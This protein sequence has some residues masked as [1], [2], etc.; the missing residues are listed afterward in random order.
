MLLIATTVSNWLLPYWIICVVQNW[1]LQSSTN[2]T[3]LKHFYLFLKTKKLYLK[4]VL[5]RIHVVLPSQRGEWQR[6]AFSN[7]QVS[8]DALASL[9]LVLE[10]PAQ[11]WVLVTALLVLLVMVVVVTGAQAAW[12]VFWWGENVAWRVYKAE[13]ELLL[14]TEI[15]IYCTYD[16]V[17]HAS[18]RYS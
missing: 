7:L 11:Q 2:P 6:A 4:V 9:V 5:P 16:A 17:L 12:C 18:V 8:N 1:T 13:A 3:L 14:H 10:V 15:C